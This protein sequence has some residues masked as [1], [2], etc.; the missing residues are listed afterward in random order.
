MQSIYNMLLGMPLCIVVTQLFSLKTMQGRFFNT[1]YLYE[2]LYF[3]HLIFFSTG[4][5]YVFHVI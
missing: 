5:T 2:F 4:A 1:S 3:L